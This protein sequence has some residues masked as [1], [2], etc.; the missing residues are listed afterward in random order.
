MWFSA[1]GTHAPVSVNVADEMAWREG[2]YVFYRTRLSD[3]VREVERYRPGSILI[4]ASALANQTV[5]GSFSLVDSDAALA[6]LQASVG[7]QMHK[8]TE[9]LVIISP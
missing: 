9:R 7:F 3:V 8:V 6:S 1:S 2:R 4:P 5:T